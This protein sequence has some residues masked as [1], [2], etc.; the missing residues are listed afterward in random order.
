M[1]DDYAFVEFTTTNATG[2]ALTAM[3]G[4]RLA[5]TKIVVEE[6]RPK[7]GATTT[8][9]VAGSLAKRAPLNSLQNQTGLDPKLAAGPGMKF[10]NRGRRLSPRRS[11]SRS[12]SRSNDKKL[13]K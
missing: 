1:K 13:K 10:A 5:G 11:I 8:A 6:A 4:A 9:T 3:N 2:K 7:E 12:R